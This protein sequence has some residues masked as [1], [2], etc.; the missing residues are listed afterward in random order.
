MFD[1]EHNSPEPT[2][3]RTNIYIRIR[4]PK[5]KGVGMWVAPVSELEEEEFILAR[6]S[7]FKVHKIQV[8]ETGTYLV[9]MEL[10][11]RHVQDYESIIKSM[12]PSNSKNYNKFTWSLGDL[13]KLG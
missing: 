10:I 8:D 12:Q 3:S 2:T 6:G 5:G 9:E 1:K 7:Q 11:G 4:V 13:I